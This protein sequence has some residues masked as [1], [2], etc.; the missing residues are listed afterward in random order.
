MFNPLLRCLADE[1]L[2]RS[3]QMRLKDLL[4][5]LGSIISFAAV[6]RVLVAVEHRDDTLPKSLTT[7]VR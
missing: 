3:H 6:V 5:A 7:V 4:D 2:Q 1:L